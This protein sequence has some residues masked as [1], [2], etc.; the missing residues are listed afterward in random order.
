M[1][2]FRAAVLK[3]DDVLAMLEAKVEARG[4]SMLA[5]SRARTSVLTCYQQLERFVNRE[6]P[7]D[8]VPEDLDSYVVPH[9][10]IRQRLHEGEDLFANDCINQIVGVITKVKKKRDP[11]SP[12]FRR[13]EIPTFL[14]GGGSAM[15]VYRDLVPI[16]DSRLAGT[17]GGVHLDLVE[18]DMP[19][20]LEI[21]DQ[22][23]PFHRLAVAW[24]LS[25][26]SHDFGVMRPR[27]Q[28]EDIEPENTRDD[29]WKRPDAFVS[30]DMV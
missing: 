25:H 12:A 15:A 2:Q 7:L 4:A 14:C 13:R 27:S 23:L 26:P 19:E 21:E 8:P 18:L 29:W 24:G 17:T 20:N 1:D 3:D 5:R 6:D 16:C 10:L 9:E 28:I 22:R 30:K 11:H